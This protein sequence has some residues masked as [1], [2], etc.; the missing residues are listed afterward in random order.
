MNLRLQQRQDLIR[1]RRERRKLTRR[2]RVRRQIVRFLLLCLLLAGAASGFLFMPWSVADPDR[3]IVV[4]GNQFVDIDQVRSALASCAGKPIYRLD[5]KLMEARVRALDPVRFAF[6]RRYA[7]PRPH[8]VVN[9]LEESPWATFATDPEGEP[10][11]VISETG[12][13]IP[14]AEYPRIFKP[15]FKIYGPDGLKLTKNEVS[16]WATWVAFIAAQTGQKVDYVDL[17]QKQCIWVGDGDL[18]LKIGVA[19]STLIRRLGRLASVVPILDQIEAPTQFIDLAL[20]NNIPIKVAKVDPHHRPAD[21]DP[22]ADAA[23]ADEPH[24]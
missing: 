10:E 12:R 22:A 19:D 21:S 17:R 23:P 6:V 4:Q 3:D 13:M 16:Q 8:L 18:L 9:V 7:L 5:P 1:R 20:D 11:A 2:A 15:D 14:I 24:L